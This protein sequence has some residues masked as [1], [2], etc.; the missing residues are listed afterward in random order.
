MLKKAISLVMCVLLIA[1]CFYGCSGSDESIDF[2]Y[3]FNAEINSFDPQ[4][5]STEDEFLIIENCFEGLVRILDDGTVMPAV[6]QSWSISDDGLTYTFNLRK[7]A[8]WNVYS[9]DEDNLTKAQQLMGADFN[10][11]ITAND[12]VFALRRAVSSETKAPLY[13][14]VSGI[15]NASKVNSG[16]IDSSKLGVNAID[17]Y[18]LEIKLEGADEGF[19]NTLSTAVAMPCNEEYFYATKGRY[20]LGLDYTIFNG[21]FYVSSILEASYIL[22]NNSLY[23]GINPSEISDITLNIIDTDSNIPK[24]LKSGYYDSAYISGSEY[25]QL[26]D[27]DIT[28]LPY[29]NK[30]WAVVLNKNKLI[31]SNINLRKAVCS[32]ISPPDI[33]EHT[34]LTAAQCF[35]PPSCLINGKSASDEIG[36]TIIAHNADTAKELW[37]KGLEETGYS[38]A[39]LTMIVSEDMEDTAKSLVQGIQSSVG[40]ISSYGESG[41]ISFS[42]KIEVLSEEDYSSALSDGNYDI[43]LYKFTASSHSSAAFLE[44]LINS[45]IAGEISEAEAALEKAKNADASSL[46]RACRECEKAIMADCSILPVMFEASYYAQA[47][48]VSGVNFHAGSGRVCFVYATRKN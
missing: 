10:P 33:S 47:K 13:S 39:D 1:A 2:I 18:T 12:F 24:N 17:D 5:A 20:G 40:T 30:M 8:K 32:S 22:K 21:Q 14:S 29:S 37:R 19:L 25:E 16:L 27:D 15:V 42:L 23:T 6:A 11:D 9:E 4:V 43:A 31:F 45:N 35:T 38:S 44:D 36:S 34:Y 41:K 46:A 48:G 28:V 3:P 7:G 26:D